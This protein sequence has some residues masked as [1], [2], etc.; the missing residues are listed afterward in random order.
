ML[1]ISLKVTCKQN[2]VQHPYVYHIIEEHIK[3]FKTT[4]L[5][6]L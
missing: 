3:T 2:Q 4:M 1:L 6:A 5:C